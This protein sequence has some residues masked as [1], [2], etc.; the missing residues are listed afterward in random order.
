MKKNA[1]AAALSQWIQ[2]YRLD[3]ILNEQTMRSLELFAYGKDDVVFADGDRLSHLLL[4]VSGKLKLYKLLPNG[5]T[6]LIRF[7][8]PL[9]VIGDVELLHG[10]AANCHA[11]SV[12][13][14][15]VI[16]IPFDSL[17]E[18]AYDDPRFLRFIIHHLG[19]KL[20]TLS[21]ASTLNLLYPLENRFASYLVSITGYGNE[22]SV[23]DTE[24]IQTPKLTE[25]AELLGTS[26]RHLNRVITKFVSA[27]VLERRRGALLVRDIQQLHG[28]A[29]G[30]VYN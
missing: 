8:K 16:A 4:V 6:I 26:Y 21:N 3:R 7:Y 13:A 5:R 9:S 20:L 27:G 23:N 17:K 22:G 30:N 24:E 19:S 14:T 2:A 15:Q 1:D 18:T 28:L 29:D 11:Q 12:Q 25:V 10:H